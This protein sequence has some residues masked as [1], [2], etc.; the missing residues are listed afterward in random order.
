MSSSDQ[1]PER[2]QQDTVIVEDITHEEDIKRLLRTM[3]DHQISLYVRMGEVKETLQEMAKRNSDD[4][5][6]LM[7]LMKATLAPQ[8][9]PAPPQQAGEA[10][11]GTKVIAATANTPAVP[12]EAMMA[13][14]GSPGA[15]AGRQLAGGGTHGGGG[16][17]ADPQGGAARRAGPGSG[18][19]NHGPG[20]LPTPTAQEM[21]ARRG[22]AKMPGYDSVEME[23]E[24]MDQE[25]GR[26]RTQSNRGP[27]E[28]R[29]VWARSAEEMSLIDQA[30]EWAEP[31][32][33]RGPRRGD[34][35]PDRSKMGDGWL[36][37]EGRP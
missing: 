10:A 8:G 17:G 35:P 26:G 37:H 4:L 34:R 16:E 36:N 28:R 5:R 3:A 19:G 7:E 11:A 21:A 12:T 29:A 13:A 22:K 18:Q 1:S 24:P 30:R 14:A 20:L 15:M 33:Q 27:N 2:R 25:T 6:S 31:E 9:L 23:F 32:S